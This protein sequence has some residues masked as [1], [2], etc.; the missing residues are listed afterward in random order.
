M[1]VKQCPG[2]IVAFRQAD[3]TVLHVTI[4]MSA[5]VVSA[6]LVKPPVSARNASSPP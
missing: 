6:T 5:A 1:H 2:P 3:A 4:G